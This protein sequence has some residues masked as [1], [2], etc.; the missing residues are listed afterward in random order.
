MEIQKIT[1][2]DAHDRFVKFNEQ[3]DYIGEG[4]QACIDNRPPE[5]TMPFYVFAHTRTIELDERLSIYQDDLMAS[6]YNALPRKYKSMEDVPTARLIWSPRLTK[7]KAQT[8]SMLFKAYPG[9]DNV[10]P[11]WIIPARELW[12]QYDKDKMTQ[13]N[14]VAQSIFD[15]INNRELLEKI[16]DDDLTEEEAIKVRIRIGRGARDKKTQEEKKKHFQEFKMI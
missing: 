3:K 5:I 9:T 4:C 15:F 7:P 2:I 11:I 6:L 1:R 10:R 16:E 13:Q 14:F 12:G 8:N